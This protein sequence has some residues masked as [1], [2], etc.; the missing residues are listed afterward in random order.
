MAGQWFVI[1][2]G[3]PVEVARHAGALAPDVDGPM[4]HTVGQRS[5]A[6]RGRRGRKD[7]QDREQKQQD[8]AQGAHGSLLGCMR[9]CGYGS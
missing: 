6:L 1:R 5:T 2:P 8:G 7:Q 9:W 3:G 4:Q